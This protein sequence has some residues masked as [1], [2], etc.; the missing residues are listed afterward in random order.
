MR[1]ADLGR[2]EG[3]VCVS[4]VAGDID[5]FILR[6]GLLYYGIT[7]LQVSRMLGQF[8]VC[9]MVRLDFEQTC[10]DAGGT[11]QPPQQAREP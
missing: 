4:T 3:A 1:W 8:S 10:F 7:N 5:D 6:R 11:T 2:Q 9:R